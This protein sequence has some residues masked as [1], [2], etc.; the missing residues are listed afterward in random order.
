[1]SEQNEVNVSAGALRDL[2]SAALLAAGATVACAHATAKESGAKVL[3]APSP[4][5]SADVVRLGWLTALSAPCS[6]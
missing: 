5:G 4:P 1:M 2:T 3:L 6:V